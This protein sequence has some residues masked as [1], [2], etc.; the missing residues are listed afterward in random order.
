MVNVPLHQTTRVI[1]RQ[2]REFGHVPTQVVLEISAPEIVQ[3]RDRSNR[4]V[5]P[6]LSIVKIAVSSNAYVS[7]TLPFSSHLR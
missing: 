1:E 4:C 7:I 3:P 2:R 6:R 5:C